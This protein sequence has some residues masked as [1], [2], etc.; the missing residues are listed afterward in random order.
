MDDSTTNG[1]DNF[2]VMLVE[3]AYSLNIGAT[4]RAMM[5]LG[6]RH[7]H[8]VAPKKYDPVRAHSTALAAESILH[9]MRFHETF[10]EAI[11]DME[12]VVG[13]ALRRG[14]NP[15][16]YVTLSEWASQ[17]P[18]RST[19]KTALVFGPEDNGLRFEHLNYCR[20]IVRI[21]STSEFESFNLAQSVLLVLYEIAKA[22]P[23]AVALN[24]PQE[25]RRWPTSNDLFQ[26]DRLLDNVMRESG[27]IR[28]GSP[29]PTPD[30]V[31]N[32]FGRLDLT[33]QEV[34]ILLSLF[35]RIDIALRRNPPPEE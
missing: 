22:L 4:A 26:L 27:F 13:L 15:A 33:T 35:G 18:Q 3:P 14:R 25:V 1:L 20:W 12:E 9:T 29:T 28:G 24:V 32:L 21:P 8:L 30:A 31:K 11:G 16:N 23:D 10:P 2:H 19:R 34:G 6:F 7:L 17:L 5:N